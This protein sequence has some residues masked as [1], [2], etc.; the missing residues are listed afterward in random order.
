MGDLLGKILKWFIYTGAIGIMLLA[1]LVGIT[2]LLLPLVEDYQDD[3]RSWAAEAIGFDVQFENISASWP[4][5]GP[6]LQF[7]NVTVLSQETGEQVFIA[8]KLTVGISLFMLLRDRKALLNRLGIEGLQVS[9]R[10]DGDGT[11]FV[12]NRSLKEFIRLESDPDGP[13]QLPELEIELSAIEVVFADD[14]RS[15]DEYTFSIEQLDIQLSAEQIRID[16]EIELASEFGGRVA[17]SADLPTRLLRPES[18]PVGKANRQSVVRDVPEWRIH[19]AGENL[20][21]GRIFA[22]ALDRDVPVIEAYGNATVSAAFIDSVLKNISGDLDIQDVVLRINADR[23]EQ[24]K[25]LSGRLEWARGENDSWLLAANEISVEQLGLFAPQSD[26]SVA[27]QPTT[28]TQDQSIQAS[29]GFIRFQ[30]LYPFILLADSEDLLAAVLPEKFHLPQDIYGDLRNFDFN[31][32]QSIDAA[33]NFKTAFE[34]TDIGIVGLGE[35][36][37]LRGASGELDADQDGGYLRTDSRDV[38]VTLPAL[39]TEP[40]QA[41]SIAGKLDWRVNDDAVNVLS[42]IIQLRLAAFQGKGRFKFDWPR[43][44][45]SPQIDLTA[46]GSANNVSQVVPLLPLKKFPPRVGA[47][48]DRALVKGRVPRAD[49][50]VSGP[51]RKFP[52]A[53]GEG[54]FNIDIDVEDCVLD[55]ADLWPRIDNL[56]ARIIFDGASLSTQRNSG[57]IGLIQFLDSDVR[58]ADLRKGQLEIHA[59]QPVTVEA[60]LEFLRQSPVALAIGPVIDNATG[61]GS[62]D[63]DLQLDMPIMQ[64]KEYQLDIVIDAND[65]ELGLQGLDWGLTNL[66]GILT[67]H[68]T[69]FHAGGMTATL[70][71]EPVTIDLYPAAASSEL[72]SQFIRVTGRTPVE[73]WMRTLSLPFIG[74]VEGAANWDALVVIP[75]RQSDAQ[76]PAHIMVR[77]DLVGVKS[78]LPDPL[79]KTFAGQRALE[80][81]I[82]FPAED[83]LEVAGR[84]EHDLT[85]AFELEA[86]TEAWEIAYGAVHAGSTPSIVSNRPGVELSGHLGFLNFDEWL[87]LDAGDLAGDAQAEA[88]GSGFGGSSWQEIWHTADL[89]VDRLVVFGQLFTAVQLAAFQ[90][91]QNWQIA[92]ESPG[93]AGQITVPLNLDAGQPILADMERLWLVDN[94]QDSQDEGGSSDPR[95]IPSVAIKADDFVMNDQHFGALSTTINSVAGG[96]LV[97]PLR[98]QSPTF[99][100]DGR[101]AWLVHPNDDTLRQTR[102]KLDLNGTDIRAVLSALG[103]EPVITGKSVVASAELTWLGG[104]G[105]DFLERANGEFTLSMKDGSLLAVEPGGGRI[106]GVL[107]LAALPRRLLFD[108]SDVFADGLSFNTIKGDF[109]VDG[110]NA[111]TCN[112]GMEGSVADM[113][114]VGRT[115]LA[116]RDYNQM[117]VIR[118]HVSNLLAVGGTVVGGPVV[119]A[120]MLLFSQI[121]HKPLSTF[122]ESYYR[123]TESWDD[124]AI[125]QISGTDLDVAPLRNCESYLSEAI[126]ESLK[127]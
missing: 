45:D 120:A 15:G 124:P 118:P 44:G 70:L 35:G 99:T 40:I 92:L 48:L 123:V 77:S 65:T 21:F 14:L 96:I 54:V 125:A 76:Q 7:I 122:G 97:E 43:N 4:F 119:G 109:T 117:A 106:L 59:Q 83:R 100:I 27:V 82:V 5:A 113:G 69:R 105:A 95:V 47:W 72:Y 39:F 49:I 61:R 36:N 32:Q 126:T 57:R 63:V 31:F 87:A 34:F 80:L 91:E 26:F 58:I 17:L 46:M 127:E 78:H 89:D 19:F 52:F 18:P 62:A 66:G 60:V 94:Y 121:F 2:R 22:Y 23:T 74:R 115:G 28:A 30:D 85:W 11:F 1:L 73:R 116:A 108:F 3:I 42:D 75:R 20:H 81:D 112:L 55:Y 12:Q 37:S 33:V 13:L 56:D 16:S 79:A 64:A 50:R 51:L 38:V 110:G 6:E 98:M 67:I 8:D 9:V 53:A 88:D 90:D 41:Q 114:I 84:L 71:G 103:Y 101:G 29:A 104:P 10:Q 93:L 102:L 111:Y 25:A 24:Y 107:S 86:G 68:N